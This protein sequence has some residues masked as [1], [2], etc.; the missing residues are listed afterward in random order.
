MSLLVIILV[1]AV[2][3]APKDGT[4]ILVADGGQMAVVKWRGIGTRR[5]WSS[6]QIYTEEGWFG[7]DFYPT[8]WMPLPPKPEPTP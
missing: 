4:E 5:L 6:W 1:A 8:H 7:T 2:M 3:C